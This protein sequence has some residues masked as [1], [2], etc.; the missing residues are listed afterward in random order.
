MS[1]L[2]YF[3]IGLFV[4]ILFL[5]IYFRV[6]VFNL[7]KILVQNE[8]QFDTSHFFN[9]KKMEREVL[10]KYPKF[11]TE[12]TMFV[13]HIK[14]SITIASILIFLIILAGYIIKNG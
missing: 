11:R 14:R 10:Q 4:A 1:I 6:K 8:I 12:I 2:M 7:Y 3:V 13:K 9:Q 5:N